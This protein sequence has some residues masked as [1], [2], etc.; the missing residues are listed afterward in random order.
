MKRRDAIRALF[1]AS[2]SHLAPGRLRLM[3]RPAF[4]ASRRLPATRSA[5][6]YPVTN[7][8]EVDAALVAARVA[9]ADA[10]VLF[11]DPITLAG[12]ERIAAFAFAAQAA[13]GVRL[14]QLCAC[15]RPRHLRSESDRGVA[16]HRNLRGPDSEG[17][18]AS[19]LP[20]EQPTIFELV[21]NRKTATALGI[22]IPE[23]ILTQADRLIE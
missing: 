11:P 8:H 2:S 21:V 10:L 22:D 7:M 23:S 13:P 17:H 15:R 12:R 1:A 20:I 14:G 4:V 19:D 16:A 3:A 6:F 5:G 9:G 18:E